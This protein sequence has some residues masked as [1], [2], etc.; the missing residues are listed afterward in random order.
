MHIY[1]KKSI[2]ANNMHTH[3]HK[4]THIHTHTHTDTH[5]HIHTHTL[6]RPTLTWDLLGPADHMDQLLVG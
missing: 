5:T 4:H 6:A 3:I 1:K 2:D